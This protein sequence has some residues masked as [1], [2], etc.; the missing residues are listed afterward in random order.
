MSSAAMEWAMH[1]HRIE[2]AVHSATSAS[3]A[4]EILRRGCE[5]LALH[6]AQIHAEGT[7]QAYIDAANRPEY[8]EQ[9]RSIMQERWD[10]LAGK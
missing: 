6:L 8:D 5:E 10:L 9:V 1:Q 7:H 4:K 3:S 2:R